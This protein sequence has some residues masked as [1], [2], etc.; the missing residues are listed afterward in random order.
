MAPSMMLGASPFTGTVTPSNALAVA[1]VYACVRALSDAAG[2]LPLHVYRRQDDGRQRLHNATSALLERPAPATTTANLISTAMAHLQTHG[3]CFLAKYRRGGRIEQLGLL[4]PDRVTVAI[5]AGEPV[6]T[7]THGTG[8]QTRHGTGDIVHVKGMS[9]DGLVGLS[10]IR[11]CRVALGLADSLAQHGAAFM[12]NDARPGGLLKT[13]HGAPDQLDSL[14]EAWESGHKGAANAHRIAVV[15]GEVSFEAI[16][17]PPDDMQF[18]EQRK[19]STVEVARIFRVPP[20]VIGADPGSSLTYQTAETAALDFAKFSL[21]PWLV[22]I[23]QALSADRDLFTGPTYCE[24]SM[25]ALLRADSATRAAVYTA[26]LDPITG[27]MS[28]AEVRMLENLPPE[29]AKTAAPRQPA[30]MV[31]EPAMSVNGNGNG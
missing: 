19:L 30:P 20:H 27:Y 9:T 12:E 28:R 31:P 7:L 6:Y 8:R 26:A 23:E 14:R 16:G 13:A 25:D 17:M 1:D 29:P 15:S 18:V 24:F 10:P 21:R 22:L 5:E 11:Q 2:S 3:N 4:Q